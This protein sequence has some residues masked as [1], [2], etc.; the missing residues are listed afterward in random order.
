MK[1]YEAALARFTEQTR[2]LEFD[3]TEGRVRKYAI[4]GMFDV[5]IRYEDVPEEEREVSVEDASGERTV[6]VTMVPASP[7]EGLLR[8]DH[9]NRQLCYEHITA[10]MKTLFRESKVS[11]DPLTEEE[12]Q[13]FYYAVIR[14]MADDR[15]RQCGIEPQN[16]WRVTEEER[17]AA[18]GQ[19]TPEQRA[20][21]I[22][23][24]LL[25]FFR[26]TARDYNCTDEEVDTRLMCRFADLNFEAQSRILQE[27]YLATYERR[28]TKLQEQID[29]LKA[30]E[31]ARALAESRELDAASDSEELP[32]E[33][34]AMPDT[35]IPAP[36]AE[37]LIIPA[38]P[39]FGPNETAESLAA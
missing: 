8:Q 18:A 15:L 28:R 33:P 3:V 10:D 35:E 39:E 5:E 38:D 19:L 16:Q 22:R 13:M 26:T 17:F 2:Q 36:P 4:I 12:H 30:Q 7:M 14:H 21:M 29:D 24:F 32:E 23:F 31:E 34:E 1:R 6:Y 11:G 25:D 27:K 20:A 37:P 9:R